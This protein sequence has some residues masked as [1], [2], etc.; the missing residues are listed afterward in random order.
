MGCV[1][2]DETRRALVAGE[3]GEATR[4][5]T[6]AV[7]VTSIKN[8]P[9][10]MF[11]TRLENLALAS[12]A[13]RLQSVGRDARVSERS[14]RSH[15]HRLRVPRPPP[16]SFLQF[17]MASP[18]ARSDG[19]G[20]HPQGTTNVRLDP[21][22]VEDLETLIVTQRAVI[23]DLGDKLRVLNDRADACEAERDGL[24]RML[25]RVGETLTAER[26]S[27]SRADPDPSSPVAAAT[28]AVEEDPFDAARDETNVSADAFSPT[29]S[30]D[31]TVPSSEGDGWSSLPLV[32]AAARREGWLVRPSDVVVP[33]PSNATASDALG[34]G[35]SGFILRGRWCGQMV[36]VK[37]VRVDGATR[38]ASF[39]REVSVSARLRHPNVLPF[40]GAC[41]APPDACLIL[42]HLCEGGTVK[43]WLHPSDPSVEPPALS[44]RLRVVWDISRGMSYLASRD[45]PIVHRDLKPGN[46][47]FATDNRAVI[48][49]LGL[50]R[51]RPPR[52]S[53]EIMTGETGTYL[54]MAPEVIRH[55]RYDS[56]ADAWSF[57]V[58]LLELASGSRPYPEERLAREMSP[59]QI[60]IGVADGLVRPK[61]SEGIHPGVSAVAVACAS[62]EP[63]ERPTF[64]RVVDSLDAMLPEVIGEAERRERGDAG[65][66][67]GLAGMFQGMFGGEGG[68]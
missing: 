60:A 24:R 2:C 16:A 55:E 51:A 42:T 47:F 25:A 9:A 34:E 26:R 53:D 66:T 19:A 46:V 64:E 14:G 23:A 59:T 3:E 10:S 49:D 54:Y 48:A 6:R 43:D 13:R 8:E 17:S 21:G 32:A 57:G 22:R 58:T 1:R 37:R 4:A 18:P 50:A 41:L 15:S 45:P 35:S 61:A 62:F 7:G 68:G 52:D 20:G 29:D 44:R 67:Q 38:A 11:S 5:S 28:T 63:K 30:T 33:S 31:P 12:R 56:A 36:A 27:R 39:L 40:Y 65:A